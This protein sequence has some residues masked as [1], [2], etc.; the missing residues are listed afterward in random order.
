MLLSLQRFAQ[1]VTLYNKLKQACNILFTTVDW[2]LSEL[3]ENFKQSRFL[4]GFY[5]APL[6]GFPVSLGFMNRL[7]TE[8]SPP[9]MF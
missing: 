1:H 6:T 8:I 3:N 9:E 2:V 7:F 5:L 4:R